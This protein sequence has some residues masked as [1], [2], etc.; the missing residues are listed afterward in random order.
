MRD[1]IYQERSWELSYELKR[2]F[3]MVQRGEDY[4]ISQM[5]QNDPFANQLGNV[6]GYRMRLPIPLE[7]IQKNPALTQNTGY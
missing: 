1:L 2:W 5:T 3:D 6:V 4:F 7:E